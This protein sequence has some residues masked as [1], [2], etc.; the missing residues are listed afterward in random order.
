MSLLIRNAYRPIRLTRQ[1]DRMFD[2]WFNEA[3]RPVGRPVLDTVELPLDVRA[4]GDEFVV[5]AA[6]PGLKAE[7]L[8]VEVLGDLVT[9]QAQVNA[10][11]GEGHDG[12]WLMRERV[13]GTFRRAFRLPAEVDSDKVE[14]TLENGVLSLRLPKAESAKPKTVAIKAK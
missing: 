5:S 3:A 8:A 9:I 7:D 1:M 12:N 4:T 14:A 10:P 6:V 13:Y 2:R 11:E